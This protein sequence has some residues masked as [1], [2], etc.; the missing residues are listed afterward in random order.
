[1]PESE[2]IVDAG[3]PDLEDLD[4]WLAAREAALGD[5]RP[6]ADARVVWAS[7]TRTAGRRRTPLS[8]VY[9][10]GFSASRMETAPLCDRL[11]AAL[12]ANLFYAR[13]AG[14]GRTP[15]AMGAE[16]MQDWLDDGA[17]ALEIGRR[18]GERVI[19][20]GTSTGGTLATLLAA[21]APPQLAALV[22]LAPNFWPNDGRV[23]LLTWPGART[24][25]PWVVGHT[26]VVPPENEGHARH[27][28]T[29][30]PSVS[31]IP[32]MQLVRAVQRA[33]LERIRVP[34]LAVYSNDDQV[35]DSR[36]TPPVLARMTGTEVETE[37]LTP[38]AHPA[39]PNPSQHVLAGDV[40]APGGT[41]PVVER[42]LRFL[43]DRGLA[44]G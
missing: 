35:V 43:S 32:M 28:T 41:A 26:R 39:V 10:H 29:T 27:W 38:E 25:V 19:L 30:Y 34:V 31:L 17:L 33:P 40:F 20:I 22:L 11:A 36:R 44:P 3:I 21:S 6:D 14:H 13:L 23:G 16:T 9:L 15:E 2:P 24:W 8:L 4:A 18:L 5:V 1:M 7:G 42:I 37:L 12:G